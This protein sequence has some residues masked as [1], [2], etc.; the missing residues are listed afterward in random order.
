MKK[1]INVA[2]ET[3]YP[4]ST[5]HMILSFG[6]SVYNTGYTMLFPHL[7]IKKNLIISIISNRC[8]QSFCKVNREWDLFLV[9]VKK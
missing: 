3:D 2:S 8:E 9:I 1:A 4:T 6:F 5:E 7:L